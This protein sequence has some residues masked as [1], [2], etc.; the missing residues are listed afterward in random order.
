MTALLRLPGGLAAVIFDLGAEE[1]EA[2]PAAGLAVDRVPL[3]RAMGGA[4]TLRV[5][6]PAHQ[7]APW[8]AV[9]SV[10]MAG[11]RLAGWVVLFHAAPT[12]ARTAV[13]FAAG[14]PTPLKILTG[15]LSPGM[16]DIW[17]N[18]WLEDNLAA[19]APR[20][21]ALYFEG[22]PGSYFLRHRP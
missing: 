20:A 8:R 5:L 15:G 9:E 18:G 4:L 13:S 11:V 3:P 21:G 14:G 12:S 2:S 17:R 7:A 16:W 10:E 19:V 22:R 1:P 6:Q